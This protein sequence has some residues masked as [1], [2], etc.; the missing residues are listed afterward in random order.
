MTMHLPKVYCYAHAHMH[1]LEMHANRANFLGKQLELW[2][3]FTDKYA[4]FNSELATLHAISH[5]DVI[6]L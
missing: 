3:F 6:C 1:S 4:N 2:F 5:V